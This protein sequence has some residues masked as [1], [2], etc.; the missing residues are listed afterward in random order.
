MVIFKTTFLVTIVTNS[1]H[2]LHS[3]PLESSLKGETG[4][5]F[6][7]FFCVCDLIF[8]IIAIKVGMNFIAKKERKKYIEVFLLSRG[9]G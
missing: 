2:S 4:E 7:Y 9:L 1:N 6:T 5:G 8:F 3:K